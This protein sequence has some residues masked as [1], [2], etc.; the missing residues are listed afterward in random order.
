MA[1]E[2]GRRRA[3]LAVAPEAR[4]GRSV[5]GDVEPARARASRPRADAARSRQLALVRVAGTGAEAQSAG[6][7]GDG[8]LDVPRAPTVDGFGVGLPDAVEAPR[9]RRLEL[10]LTR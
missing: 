8:H 4:E 6:L 9:S 10:R 2:R 5:E 1:V 7:L 3:I